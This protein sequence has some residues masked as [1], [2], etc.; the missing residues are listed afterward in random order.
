MAESKIEFG[1]AGYKFVKLFAGRG[2]AR[3]PYGGI[4]ESINTTGIQNCFFSC[5]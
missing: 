1:A 3:V 4:L 2:G 5:R